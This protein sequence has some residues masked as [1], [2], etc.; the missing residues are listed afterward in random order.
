M[1]SFVARLGKTCRA[2]MVNK[3][4]L[5]ARWRRRKTSNSL[6]DRHFHGISVI[7]TAFADGV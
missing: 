5:P 4:F 1:L 2:N 7:G 6:K 3:T